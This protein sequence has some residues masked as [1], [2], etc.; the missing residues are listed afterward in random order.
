MGPV[1]SSQV[2]IYRHGT[3]PPYDY[4]LCPSTDYA[5]N[6]SGPPGTSYSS[7]YFSGDFSST[8]GYGNQAG[9]TTSSNYTGGYISVNA[10]NTCNSSAVTVGR[11]FSLSYSCPYSMMTSADVNVYPN[12]ATAE[13]TIE[14]PDEADVTE[15]LVYSS[16]KEIV[17]QKMINKTLNESKVILNLV[18]LLPDT[19]YLHLT[20]GKHIVQKQMVKL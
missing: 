19:Y 20:N 10:S 11:T 16:S 14:W 4:T 5:I 9:I 17:R 18:D 3:F 7:W 1:Q 6:A 13:I 2:N 15:V 8:Y 12:P